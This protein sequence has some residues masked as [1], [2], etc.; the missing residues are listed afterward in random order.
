MA[1]ENGDNMFDY[2]SIL[3]EK[4]KED[5]DIFTKALQ[6]I[7]LFQQRNDYPYC[8]EELSQVCEKML[9]YNLDTVTDGLWKY[10]IRF[11]DEMIWDPQHVLEDEKYPDGNLLYGLPEKEGKQLAN[12][13]KNEME[14]FFITLSPLFETLYYGDTDLSGIDK[15]AKKQTYGDKK[16]IRLIRKD[17]NTFDFSANDKEIDSII[18]VLAHMKSWGA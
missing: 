6:V 3:F 11:S 10:C 15:I 1:F 4:Y 9:G 16:T 18:N 17:G 5:K 12:D 13:F 2:C 14:V 8:T 7:S